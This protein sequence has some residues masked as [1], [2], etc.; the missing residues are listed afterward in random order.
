MYISQS[1]RPIVFVL[2]NFQRK[3]ASLM[4]PPTDGTTKALVRYKGRPVV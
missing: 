3:F 1:L 2:E 4:A